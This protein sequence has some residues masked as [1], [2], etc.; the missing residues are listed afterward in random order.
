MANSYGN[1]DR[2]MDTIKQSLEYKVNALKE[3]GVGIAQNLF[4]KEDMKIV[5]DGL[6]GFL[7][8][9]DKIT[10]SLGLFKTTLLTGGLITGIKSIV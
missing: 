10:D 9:I 2:E 6:T 8:I 7:E 1:A 5:V 4:K 3:T